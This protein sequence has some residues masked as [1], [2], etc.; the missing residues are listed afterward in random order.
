MGTLI[1][2]S[3]SLHLILQHPQ[4]PNMLQALKKTHLTHLP[5]VQTGSFKEKKKKKTKPKTTQ[6]SR[7][8]G[9]M[10]KVSK[11]KA[12]YMLPYWLCFPQQRIVLSIA[13]ELK[14]L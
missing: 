10:L 14:H 11:A 13:D 3:H 6:L 7:G 4:L 2:G 5:T 1:P 12:I 8:S 9:I